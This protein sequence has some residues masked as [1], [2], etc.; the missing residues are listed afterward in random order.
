MGDGRVW[1]NTKCQ[2][3]ISFLNILLAIFFGYYFRWEGVFLGS[4]LAVIIGSLYLIISYRIDNESIL[5]MINLKL[6]MQSFFVTL[7]YTLFYIYG[8]FYTLNLYSDSFLYIALI[9]TVPIS[10]LCFFIYYNPLIR[11]ILRN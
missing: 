5:K 2:L 10:L 11:K 7:I 3:L 9:I 8:W 1:H 4:S 6:T